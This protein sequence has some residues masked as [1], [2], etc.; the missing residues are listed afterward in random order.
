MQKLDAMQ[1]DEFVPYYLQLSQ[2]ER[3]IDVKD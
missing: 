1:Y 3:N 2:A